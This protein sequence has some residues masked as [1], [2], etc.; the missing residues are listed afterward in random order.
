MKKF[1]YIVLLA[2]AVLSASCKKDTPTDPQPVKKTIFKVVAHR[3]GYQ[4]SSLP[5]CCIQGLTYSHSLGC[6]AAECDI[7]ITKDSRVLV[8]HPDDNSKVNGFIPYQANL[9]QIR[10]A[11]KL[12]NG[13]DV[14]VFED[15]VA[16]LTNPSKNSKGMKIWIDTKAWSNTDYTI[17]AIN[18]A[19]KIIKGNDAYRYCEFII[20]NSGDLFAKVKETDLYKE[21]KC[22]V[23]WMADGPA[24]L[25]DPASFEANTWHQTKYNAIIPGQDIVTPKYSVDAYLKAGVDLSIWCCS[26]ESGEASSLLDKAMEYYPDPH[27]KAFFVNYPAAAIKAI[28][29]AGY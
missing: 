2:A 10:G 14:P 8:A 29:A 19:Y 11:G 12:K 16:F 18:E 28:K 3:G 27:F 13:E 6:Y 17:Q 4:E 15:F 24:K 26:T 7:V 20:P 1:S 23:G 5:A 22:N 9:D 21:K 25:L